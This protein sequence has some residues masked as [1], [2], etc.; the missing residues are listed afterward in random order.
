MTSR[1][2]AAAAAAFLLSTAVHAQSTNDSNAAIQQMQQ[3]TKAQDF[4]TMAAMSD[5]FEIRSAAVAKDQATGQSAKEL[6]QHLE[7]DHSKSSRDLLALAQK[8]GIEVSPPAELDERHQAMLQSLSGADNKA[9]DV[10]FG[11]VQ[12]QAHQEGIALFE[13]YSKNGDNAQLKAFAEQGLPK[14]KQHLE[15]AQKVAQNAQQNTGG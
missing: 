4:V 9:F 1:I 3:V 7:A 2:I 11:Q 12:V 6:A 5:M 15:M 13:A 10:T 8:E 14:L